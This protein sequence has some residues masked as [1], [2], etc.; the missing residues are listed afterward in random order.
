MARHPKLT[1]EMVGEAVR[2]KAEDGLS[3]GDIVCALGIHESAFCRKVELS[4]VA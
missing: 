3:N 1:Q 2:F 4:A